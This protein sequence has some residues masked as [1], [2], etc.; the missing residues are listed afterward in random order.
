MIYQILTKKITAPKPFLTAL[1]FVTTLSIILI[2][3]ANPS[4]DWFKKSAGYYLTANKFSYWVNDSYHYLFDQNKKNAP[5]LSEEIEFYH[6]NHPFKFTSSEYPLMHQNTDADVLGD[7]FNLNST[8]PNIVILVVEGL[9][10]DFSGANAYAGSFTPFL[11]SLSKKSLTWDK[12][13]EYCT[14]NICGASGY[15]RIIAVW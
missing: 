4:P 12:F 3:F 11:D 9:S 14:R 15:F 7:F 1:T 10:R 2:R 13:F 5:S 6:T 8:T